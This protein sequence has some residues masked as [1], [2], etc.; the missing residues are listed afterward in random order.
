MNKKGEKKE[1][2][3]RH[4][5][6]NAPNACSRSN[7]QPVARGC[8]ERRTEGGDTRGKIFSRGGGGDVGKLVGNMEAERLTNLPVRKVENEK[9]DRSWKREKEGFINYPQ[10]GNY[11]YRARSG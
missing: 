10:P 4:C 8:F 3:D 5:N 9:V 1:R 6:N 11:E 2:K 7:I